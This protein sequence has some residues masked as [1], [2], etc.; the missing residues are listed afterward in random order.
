M[1]ALP[2][3]WPFG[4]R[5]PLAPLVHSQGIHLPGLGE[6][7]HLEAV[8]GLHWPED[9]TD[10]PAAFGRGGVVQAG[11][12]VLR[13]YRRGG[14]VSYVNDRTYPDPGRFRQELQ[15]HRS[16]WE[17]GFPTVEPM[18]IA[19]RRRGWGVEGVLITR[20]AEGIP[21]PRSWDTGILPAL[22]QAVEALVAWGLWSPD[23]NATNV[24]V[25]PEGILLLDWDKAKWTD[26]TGL[27][28]RYHE[29]LI[30]S[31]QKLGAPVELLESF[32]P[33]P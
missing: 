15:V 13:S 6:D 16:L 8:P 10:M 12:L 31:L 5:A 14:L 22:H 17:A 28:A 32:Q 33:I 18:G 29:R 2:S 21:W 7:W 20:Y 4:P 3:D 27:R 26:A 23:L 1:P 30:R 9:T 24:M 19:H 25:G 11:D